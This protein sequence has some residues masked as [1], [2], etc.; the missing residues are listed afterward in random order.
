MPESE[1]PFQM[2]VFDLTGKVVFSET[3]GPVKKGEVLNID[4]SALNNGSVYLLKAGNTY[5]K[6]LKD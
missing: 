1:E 4:L 5:Q 6:L 3:F 2:Q